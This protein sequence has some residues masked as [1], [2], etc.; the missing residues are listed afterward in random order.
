M[1]LKTVGAW[2]LRCQRRIVEHSLQ[3]KLTLF[4]GDILSNCSNAQRKH[5]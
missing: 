3:N 4:T 2:L 1:C 5:S